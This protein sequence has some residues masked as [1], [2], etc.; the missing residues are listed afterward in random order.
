[1]TGLKTVLWALLLRKRM[2]DWKPLFPSLETN[3]NLSPSDPNKRNNGEDE[4]LRD[5]NG[6][7]THSGRRS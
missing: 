2:N 7:T 4:P 6:P 3:L 1:M 5:T